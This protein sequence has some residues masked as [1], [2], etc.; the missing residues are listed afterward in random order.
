MTRAFRALGQAAALVVSL[1]LVAG[2][3]AA[4]AVLGIHEPPV[5]RPDSVSLT[6][7][8]AGRILTREFTAVQQ[9]DT[10]TG[11]AVQAALRTAYAGEAL[12]AAKA[13]TKLAS[14][15]PSG[16]DSPFLA[17]Q[18]P[19]ALALSRGTAYPRVIVAQTPAPDGGFP[20]LHLLMSPAA[21]TP[22]RIIASAAML[23]S[24]SVKAFHPLSQGSPL[25][26]TQIGV[27]AN[28][29]AL[30]S[31]YA[32]R[33]AFPGK[34]LGTSPFASDPFS[35]Q[36]RAKAVAVAKE[37]AT[38]AK[39]RQVHRVIPSSVYAVRQASGDALVFGVIERTDL[40][41]VKDGQAVSTKGNDE[42]VLLTGKKKVTRSAS[43]TRLEFVVFAVPRSG[44]PATLVAVSDPVIAG[45]GS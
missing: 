39:F 31:A 44:G 37:V 43:I 19:R 4:D 29:T 38:Q 2:C 13:R 11:A 34:A 18:Q 3:G 28:G 36:V 16:A 23:P 22:Y 5:A 15:R 21:R 7:D 8:Q 42:F 20:A 14:A 25:V 12:R 27:A 32:A 26:T 33:M 17:P 1:G 40:F 24:S 6:V 10:T 30:L 9:G 35:S 41:T 45:S